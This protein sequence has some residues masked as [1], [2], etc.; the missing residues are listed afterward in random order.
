[1]KVLDLFSGLGGWSNAFKD[2]GH[3]VVTLDIEQKFNPTICTDIMKVKPEEILEGYGEFDII[4]ASPPCNCFSVASVYRHWDK[5]TRMPKDEQTYESIKL[6][7]HTINLILNMFPRWWILE[8]P[9]GMLRNVLGKPSATIFY[10]AYG[11]KVLKPTDLW[12]RL[13]NIKWKQP[14]KWEKAPRGSHSGVQGIDAKYVKA[15]QRWG[16]WR[17]DDKTIRTPELRALVPYEL[18]MAICIHCEKKLKGEKQDV[19]KV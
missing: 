3:K 11:L 8:N 13:P 2:R 10:G 9:R 14:V 15:N 12:G 16:R 18:S 19:T 5:D 17:Q 6:V 1:M 4:L 7:G